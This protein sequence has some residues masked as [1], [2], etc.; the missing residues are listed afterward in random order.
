[1]PPAPPPVT[2][3]TLDYRKIAENFVAAAS[4]RPLGAGLRPAGQPPLDGAGH[5]DGNADLPDRQ[6]LYLISRESSPAFR[7]LLKSAFRQND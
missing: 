3:Q 7:D 6:I 1:M 4:W 2:K 5:Q